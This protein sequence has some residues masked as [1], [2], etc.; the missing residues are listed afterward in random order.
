MAEAPARPRALLFDWDN[1]LADNWSAIGEALNATLVAMGQ[2]PWSA[3]EVRA[4][5]RVSLR[6]SF[7]AMFGAR[8][9]EARRVFYGRF[10]DLHLAH[11]KAL[12][13]AAAALARLSDDGFYLGVVSNKRG[14]LLR[15]EAVHLGWDAHFSALVGAGDAVRDKPAREPIDLALSPGAISAGRAVWF[16][17]DAGI[18][19]ACARA[20]G[21]VPVLIGPGPEREEFRDHPPEHHAP[22][23]SALLDLVARAR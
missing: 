18:D 2:A 10:H 9:L 1:T 22:D 19:M 5:V 7:P 4:R 12:P 3:A 21:C 11:L 16:V 15:R 17:G 14:D 8:W 6:E 20:A 23:F 13:G